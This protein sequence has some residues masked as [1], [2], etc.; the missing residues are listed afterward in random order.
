MRGSMRWLRA[1]ALLLSAA[2]TSGADERGSAVGEVRSE[3]FEARVL[4]DVVRVHA[5]TLGVEVAFSDLTLGRPGTRGTSLGTRDVD[6]DSGLLVADHGGPQSHYSLGARSLEQTFF[7]PTPPAGRRG[8]AQVEF[9]VSGLVPRSVSSEAVVLADADGA[10]R[11]HYRDLV[12]RDARGH[13]LPARLGVEGDRIAIRFDDREATYP[14]LVDPAMYA[15][16]TTLRASPTSLSAQFGYAIATSG[17]VLAVGEPN[18]TDSSTRQGTVHVFVRSSGVWTFDRRINPASARTDAFFG[19]SVAVDVVGSRARIL[20]GAPGDSNGTTTSGMAYIFERTG[21]GPFSQIPISLPGAIATAGAS[22]GASVAIDGD[23][24]VIGAASTS[25]SNGNRAQVVGFT[26][27]SVNPLQTLMPSQA[28]GDT[29]F[30]AS[31]D[32]D[33]TTIAVGAPTGDAGGTPAFG[34]VDVFTTSDSVTWTIAA[35]APSANVAGATSGARF[36]AAIDLSGS[37]VLVGAPGHNVPTAAEGKA[38][39][40]NATTGALVRATT[41]TYKPISAAFGT[42]VAFGPN[43][44]CVVGVPR[45]GLFTGG[46]AEYY[47]TCLMGS[48]QV[49]EIGSSASSFDVA[50]TSVA[51]AQNGAEVELLSGAPGRNDALITGAGAVDVA[52][53][54]LP[55]GDSCS[56][57]GECQT[58]NCVDGVCCNSAC[59][60]D[61]QSDCLVCSSTAGASANGMCTTITTG[62]CARDTGMPT[63][64]AFSDP[65]ALACAFVPGS[66]RRPAGTLALFAASVGLGV[67]ARRRRR[68]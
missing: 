53:S 63:G 14:V 48:S 26:G 49:V 57:G 55:Q 8:E 61:L 16:T 42:S 58:G 10:A 11:L 41:A 47:A 33:G 21:T 32:I 45:G 17:D 5:R 43:G 51:L 68:R 40:M 3:G 54:A 38:F 29:D 36:G 18:F 35:T 56:A 31:V 7:L 67:V 22:F 13:R 52:R 62:T 60:N 44:D 30:G 1:S 64:P 6:R 59:G 39:L 34:F 2:S 12:V 66:A 15:V 25:G 19:K 23:L 46:A 20:V 24:G 27:A 65:R 37:E 50:G 4:G 9:R 28:T